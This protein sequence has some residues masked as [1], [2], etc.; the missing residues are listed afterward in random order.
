VFGLSVGIEAAASVTASM[1]RRRSSI[2]GP[3]LDG[4]IDRS[5]GVVRQTTYLAAMAST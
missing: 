5:V 3:G 2:V 4:A 1:A